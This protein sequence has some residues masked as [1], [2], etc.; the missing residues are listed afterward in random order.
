MLKIGEFSKLSRTTVKALRF[1]ESEGLLLPASVDEWTGYRFYETSQ[2]ETAAKIKSFRQLGFTVE[3]IKNVLSGED[4]KKIL[5]AKADELRKLQH[6]T[7]VRLS[8][9][10]YIHSRGKN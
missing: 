6:D 8:V 7:A 10:K 2:L 5:L 1:Y 4:V 3:E 9:I